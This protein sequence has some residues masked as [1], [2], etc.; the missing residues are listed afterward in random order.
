MVDHIPMI[1]EVL[2]L[3]TLLVDYGYY[4]HPADVNPVVQEVV[5]YLRMPRGT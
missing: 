1:S 3:L 5:S 4:Y 2:E